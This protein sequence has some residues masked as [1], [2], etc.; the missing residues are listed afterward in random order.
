MIKPNTSKL[1]EFIETS[2]RVVDGNLVELDSELFYRISNVQKM[3]EFFMSLTSSS[4]HWM[5][6][7]SFGALTAGR[8]NSN[9]AIFPYYSADKISDSRK[10]T[11]PRTIIHLQSDSGN[12][13]VWQPFWDREI[14]TELYQRNLY[15]SP[16]GNKLC[17]EEIDIEKGLIFRYRWT[18]S[19]QFGL[20]RTSRLINFGQNNFGVDLLDGF[21]NIIPAGAEENFQLQF[22]NLLDAYKKSELTETG[23]GIYYLS[24]IPTDKAEPSEGLR[25]TIA[26]TTEKP[27]ATLLGRQQIASYLDGQPLM[28][29]KDVRARRGDY[30]LN[31][32]FE[33]N[34]G[35]LA[36][37]D[38]VADTGLD[39]T[40]I[41]NL[42]ERVQS[43]E[44]RDELHGDIAEC[45]SRLA[46]LV[47]KADGFQVSARYGK[48]M[49]HQG[50]VIFNIM[51]GGIPL[52]DYQIPAA[53][54]K[55]HVAKANRD[56]AGR[57]SELL[58]S[59]PE[60]IDRQQLVQLASDSGDS[61][62]LRIVMEYL[63]LVFSRRHGDPT[64]PWN[65]FSIDSTV[66]SDEKVLHYEGNWRDIFQNWEALAF[67]Y[68]QFVQSMICRFLNASTADGYNPYRVTKDGFEWESPEPDN[69][70]ANIGYWC[71]HQIIY[72]CKLLELSNQFFPGRLDALLNET[73]FVYAN[74]PY[75]IK[76]IEQI[77][78]SPRETVDYD[79]ELSKRLSA[80]TQ[81]LGNDAKLLKSGDGS[82]HS[83]TL[84]D[85]LLLTMLVK[86][87][88]FVPGGGVWLNT[89]RPEWNDANNALVGS[90]LSIVTT[91]YLRR[92]ASF[93]SDWLRDSGVAKFEIQK[94]VALLLDRI[95]LA[96]SP[97]VVEDETS[98][99]S[100]Q[101][102]QIVMDLSD[103]GSKY[104][105]QLYERGLASERVELDSEKLLAFLDQSIRLLDATIAGNRRSDGLYHAYNLMS[106]DVE[107][108]IHI[109]RLYEMLEGQVAVLSS[110]SLSP[111]QAVEVLTALRQSPLYRED[112]SSYM[113]YPNRELPRFLEKNNLPS[114]LI[115]QSPL[116]QELLR[117][118]DES[119]IRKDVTGNCHF[120]GDFRNRK[121][122]ETAVEN[123]AASGKFDDLLPGAA[124]QIGSIFEN[125]FHHHQ[126]TGRSGTFFAYEGLGSIYWHMVSKLLLAVSENYIL[127]ESLGLE[128]EALDSLRQHFREIQT[129]LGAEK[130]PTNYGAFP[131]DP[132]SHTPE[133]C[134]AQQ[135]GMTGQVKED[136]LSR[137]I[138]MG[139]RVNEGQIIFEPSMLDPNEFCE[140]ESELIYWNFATKQLE[141]IVLEPGSFGFTFC[142]VPIIYR[143]T[144]TAGMRVCSSDGQTDSSE[145]FVLNADQC[146]ALF[147]RN[148]KITRIELDFDA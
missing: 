11:C 80:E 128:D 133:H 27:N 46:E 9:H 23:L 19:H 42:A 72:L 28:T 41:I 143:A 18:F 34:S 8:R 25:A 39:Q 49:R 70:W 22:G 32:Q 148:G 94:E 58:D 35:D 142:G 14:D 91:C 109:E 56:V 101:R 33:L 112:Q 141:T 90:G 38:I 67:S 44:I 122:V 121:D 135:P 127:A 48:S 147:A 96:I 85:K 129:G 115:K 104:R 51:R 81:T 69:P 61:E 95:Q 15:K 26:W 100:V 97:Y 79:F 10:Q 55:L 13:Q 75:R 145:E 137:F 20:V 12:K 125:I 124:S 120:N 40:E 74:V 43:N 106:L 53:D 98:I 92:Y 87:S 93:L 50:N 24:S 116:L 1:R 37:W 16:L 138:E 110:G 123:L 65:K 30:L 76:S 126:F 86:M 5:F 130:T 71:D 132:Y 113:L 89:Q 2:N 64:R 36:E 144:G 102:H 108:E 140:T 146:D 3:P 83:A 78:A 7:S 4:D 59:L 82:I 45:E 17:F 107:G 88:N 111:Q 63:P 73:A 77:L 68:P 52:D 118:G 117:A 136:I 114:G 131:T 84:A 57:R 6:V 54:L 31:Y 119:V 134:G 47:A 105:E 62:L 60:S 21:Q 29:E 103:A 66:A 139:V 99:S